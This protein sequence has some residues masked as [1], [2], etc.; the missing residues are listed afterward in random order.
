M[1]DPAS[2]G[3]REYWLQHYRRYNANDQTR[4]RLDS[5]GQQFEW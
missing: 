3:S 1:P 2:Y 4:Y 5:H